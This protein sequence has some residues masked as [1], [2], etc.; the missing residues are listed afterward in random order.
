M[1]RERDGLVPV[2]RGQLA[3]ALVPYLGSQYPSVSGSLQAVSLVR[4]TYT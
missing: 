3:A 2:V 4:G 1:K